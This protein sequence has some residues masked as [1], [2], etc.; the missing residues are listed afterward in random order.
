MSQHNGERTQLAAFCSVSIER[1]ADTAFI[2]L[3]GELDLTCEDN[4]RA[5]VVSRMTS[6]RPSTVIVDLREL[7]FIDSCGLRML[8]WLDAAARDEGFELTLVRADGQVRKVLRITRLDRLLP[9]ERPL[10]ALNESKS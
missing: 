10:S 2:R 9:L 8:L 1:D 3:E 7:A 5:E 6:W 4:F